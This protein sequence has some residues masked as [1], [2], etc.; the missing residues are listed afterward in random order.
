LNIYGE[1][2]KLTTEG[3]Y[4]GVYSGY[5]EKDESA[6]IYLVATKIFNKANQPT[7]SE[8]LQLKNPY[9]ELYITKMNNYIR[10]E[11]QKYLDTGEFFLSDE[12]ASWPW[13]DHV[14]RLLSAD[15]YRVSVQISYALSYKIVTFNGAGDV[16]TLG[17]IF[18]VSKEK[19]L[20]KMFDLCYEAV[21]DVLLDSDNDDFLPWYKNDN[22]L[23]RDSLLRD[24]NECMESES[25]RIGKDAVILYFN[26]GIANR[27]IEIPFTELSDI[28]EDGYI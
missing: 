16:L 9:N 17:D 19:Y 13:P 23:K 14:A 18:K 5:H 1:A 26:F 25:W 21:V 24:F 4:Y 8:F 20:N 2:S 15:K 12:D 10:N 3:F 22:L 28:L 6:A 27:I 11:V 7:I